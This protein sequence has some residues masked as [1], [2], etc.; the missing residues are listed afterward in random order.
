MK[1]QSHFLGTPL[2]VCQHLKGMLI[3]K[4][5]RRRISELRCNAFDLLLILSPSLSFSSS[6]DHPP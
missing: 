2:E 6:A 1:F 4:A 3:I 5:R